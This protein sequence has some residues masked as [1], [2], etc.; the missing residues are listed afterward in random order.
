VIPP[1]NSLAVGEV[2][3]CSSVPSVAAVCTTLQRKSTRFRSC[4]SCEPP[5]STLR[6]SWADKSSSAE[7][8]PASTC[9]ILLSSSLLHEAVPVLYASHRDLPRH[10][11]GNAIGVWLHTAVVSHSYL[12]HILVTHAYISA[13]YASHRDLPRQRGSDDISV[14]LHTAVVPHIRIMNIPHT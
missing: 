4:L 5:L 12:M 10:R 9:S 2:T 1:Q 13:I 8:R 7:T 6:V 11:G 14:W 3:A